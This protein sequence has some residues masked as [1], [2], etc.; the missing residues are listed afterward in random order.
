[1]LIVVL[2]SPGWL[3][4]P[5]IPELENIMEGEIFIYVLFEKFSSKRNIKG[6]DN[7]R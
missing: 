5:L 6:L 3:K 2:V 7:R 1:M 4:L